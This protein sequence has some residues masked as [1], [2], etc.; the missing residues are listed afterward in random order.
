M[1]FIE[2]WISKI[3]DNLENIAMESYS[4]TEYQTEN[5]KNLSLIIEPFVKNYDLILGWL[6]SLH[7]ESQ[8]YANLLPPESYSFTFRQGDRIIMSVLDLKRNREFCKYI[9]NSFTKKS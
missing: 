5:H 6:K 9:H 8:G 4:T 3:K 7:D 2:I 1:I